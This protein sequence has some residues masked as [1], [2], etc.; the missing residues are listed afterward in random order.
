MDGTHNLDVLSQIQIPIEFHVILKSLLYQET[1]E[2]VEK[3]IVVGFAIERERATVVEE[4][5]KLQR[6]PLE[7]GKCGDSSFT[8]NNVIPIEPQALPRQKAPKK[9]E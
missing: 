7:Q 5:A 8:F 3:V 9:V 2:K 1:V 6:E 4:R